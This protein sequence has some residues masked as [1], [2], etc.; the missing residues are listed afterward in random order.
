MPLIYPLCNLKILADGSL[1]W[2]ILR[3]TSDLIYVDLYC[4]TLAKRLLCFPEFS[5][6]QSSRLLWPTRDT[7]EIWKVEEKLQSY[8]FYVWRASS[9]H[10]V[11]LLLR[12]LS[13]FFRR[14]GSWAC[15]PLCSARPSFR[16][17]HFWAG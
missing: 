12:M 2:P 3:E 6:L 5:V 11:L 7:H 13:L 8:L 4:V 9:G 10:E 16:F 15:V 17:S 1:S 14:V